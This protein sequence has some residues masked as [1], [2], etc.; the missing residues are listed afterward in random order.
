MA[1]PEPNILSAISSHLSSLVTNTV[2]GSPHVRIGPPADAEPKDGNSDPMVNLFLYRIEPSGFYADASSHDP[3]YVRIQCLVTAYGSTA[4]EEGDGDANSSISAGEINLR[5]LGSVL[6]VFHENPVQD[7]VFKRTNAQTALEEEIRTSLQIVF[8]SLSTE[9]INQIWATQGDAAYRSSVA[10]E[11]ALAPI[12][13]T[14]PRAIAAPVG[15]V[16]LSSGPLPFVAGAAGPGIGGNGGP[17]L[18]TIA[19]PERT[20]I[21]EAKA[22]QAELPPELLVT[23]PPAGD[24]IVLRGRTSIPEGGG[25]PVFT[26]ERD[27]IDLTFTPYEGLAGHARFLFAKQGRSWRELEHADLPDFAPAD[28]TVFQIAVPGEPGE[29]MVYV[30]LQLADAGGEA[31]IVRSNVVSLSV[32]DM[33]GPSAN[34]GGG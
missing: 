9:E 27:T 33:S 4:P 24:R 20:L 8:K 16:D 1:L 34:G 22:N 18:N 5:L 29:W 32:I 26:T 6:Q 21:A 13:P 10:Y 3:F 28:S 25:A 14:T 31:T 7:V 2:S 23:D 15:S 11:L 19:D 30:E 12:V 17:R